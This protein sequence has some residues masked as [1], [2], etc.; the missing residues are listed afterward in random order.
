MMRLLPVVLILACA[1]D[2]RAQDLPPTSAQPYPIGEGA[3]P[4]PQNENPTASLRV[5]RTPLEPVT[6]TRWHRARILN[7]FG[8]AF[9]LIGTGLSLSSTI[10]VLATGYPPSASDFVHPAK[11]SDTAPVLAFVGSGVS[12]LGFTMSAG[13]LG[14]EHRILGELGA[15][16]GR[17]MFVGGTVVGVLGVL[18]IGVSYFLAFTDYLNPRDQTIA[19]IATSLGGAALCTTASAL[20]A[21]DSSHLKRAWKTLTTF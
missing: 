9:G 6:I 4:Q 13:G 5:S 21:T 15:D 10:Y 3:Q 14:W 12:A 16:P 20:Y 18:A 8:T 1:V 7:G 2:A 17:G 19:G 11:P